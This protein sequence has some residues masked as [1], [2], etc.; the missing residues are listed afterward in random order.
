[1]DH[2]MQLGVHLPQ[3][4]GQ[5]SPDNI[6]RH[7]MRAEA[8]GLTDVWVSDHIIVP[9]DAPYPPTAVFYD[10]VVVLS[11]V[12]AVTRQV[13]TSIS[14]SSRRNRA[15]YR[16]TRSTRSRPVSVCRTQSKKSLST[17]PWMPSSASALP[18]RMAVASAA[19]R[20]STRA[21]TVFA[22]MVR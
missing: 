8:L 9:K 19:G 20:S 17:A 10:P 5:A 14:A 13:R 2:E 12:A 7:A 16:A 22:T 6:M 11:W 1:M 3:A 21:A 15:V 4:G 18:V